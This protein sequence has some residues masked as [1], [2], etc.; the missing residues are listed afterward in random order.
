MQNKVP[1]FIIGTDEIVPLPGSTFVLD[2][3]SE[4]LHLFSS[5][6]R[7][8]EEQVII[9]LSNEAN[10]ITLLADPH[11]A[12]DSLM[13]VGLMC[14]ILEREQADTFTVIT[15]E[16]QYRVLGLGALFEPS[17][18]LSEITVRTMSHLSLLLRHST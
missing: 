13:P 17:F 12:L 14:K 15:L 8:G 11:S 7:G 4:H 10:A 18:I 9:G 16:A 2:I 1:L 3:Q 5:I 6:E